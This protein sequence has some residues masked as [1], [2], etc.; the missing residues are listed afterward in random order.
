MTST[1]THPNHPCDQSHSHAALCYVHPGSLTPYANN[2]R[3]HSDAQIKQIAESIKR[4]GFTNPVLVS[5]EGEIIA[6]H[7]RV[8]AALAL[9]LSEVPTLA[10]SHLTEAE[11]HAA[12]T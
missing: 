6:G 12:P 9:G 10:L 11:R 2:A 4:F 1:T 7:G 3:T 5:D 8:R